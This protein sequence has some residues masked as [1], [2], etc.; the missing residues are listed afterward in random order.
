MERD[1]HRQGSSR[2][3]FGFSH[4]CR[5]SIAIHRC[6]RACVARQRCRAC[7]SQLESSEQWSTRAAN[8]DRDSIEALF[9]VVDGR[10]IAR[11]IQQLSAEQTRDP[12]ADGTIALGANCKCTQPPFA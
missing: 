2:L 6:S 7:A 12:G 1:R 5:L 9:R 8:L 10:S 11:D 3:A 4:L